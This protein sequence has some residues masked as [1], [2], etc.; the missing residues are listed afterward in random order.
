MYMPTFI[1]V[2]ANLA[3]YGFTSYLS[4]N[5][6]EMDYYSVIRSYG[7]YNPDVFSGQ[8]WRLLTAM[9]VH[10]NIAHIAGN[11]LFLAIFGLRAEDMFDLK[12]YLLIYFLSGFAGGLLTLL[13]GPGPPSVG[14][15]GAIFG[16]FGATIIYVRRSIG[17]S[18]MSALLYSFFLFA[19]NI[20]PN[21]NIFAHLGG[22]VAGLLIGYSLAAKRKPSQVVTYKY[23]YPT[24]YGEER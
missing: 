17:Q 12:E 11:M 14:A 20:G 9:F 21:V 23:G 8:V 16:V 3:V 22:L 10:A 5:L 2:A 4:G 13:M 6:F 24:S 18:I 1:L 7:Q 15:S 19:I